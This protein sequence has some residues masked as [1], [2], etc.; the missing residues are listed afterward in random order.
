M[1]I[2][3]TT[4]DLVTIAGF[5]Y[6]YNSACFFYRGIYYENCRIIRSSAI[7]GRYN[8]APEKKQALIFGMNGAIARALAQQ[9]TDQYTVT[10]V[11]RSAM[12]GQSFYSDQLITDYSEASLAELSERFQNKQQSFDLIINTV[13]VLHSEQLQPEKRLADLSRDSLEHY[14]ATNAII[15][16]LILKYCH[17]L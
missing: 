2:I 3:S 7:N 8:R 15:P 12:A 13:G 17:C 6:D 4:R 11:G 10:G 1:N 5:I 16:G 14:F 9:L